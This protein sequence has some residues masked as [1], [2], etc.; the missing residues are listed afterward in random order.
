M[1]SSFVYLVFLWMMMTHADCAVLFFA[2]AVMRKYHD[3]VA[4]CDVNAPFITKRLFHFNSFPTTADWDPRCGK[5][6]NLLTHVIMHQ[7]SWQYVKSI[8]FSSSPLHL[9]VRKRLMMVQWT[10]S[11]CFK[12]EYLQKWTESLWWWWLLYMTL[13]TVLFLSFLAAVI[14]VVA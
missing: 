4:S 11:A 6:F 12:I 1:L 13:C 8:V 2:S 7:T 5:F 9:S 14:A 10:S 3:C